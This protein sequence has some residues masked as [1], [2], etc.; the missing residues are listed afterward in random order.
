[1]AEMRSEMEKLQAEL[2]KTRAQL[3]E[4]DRVLPV[5]KRK[6]TLEELIAEDVV[7]HIRDARQ[8]GRDSGKASSDREYQDK[9]VSVHGCLCRSY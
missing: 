9:I 5:I 7:G 4:Q 3:W 6:K 2:E 8:A 1:M